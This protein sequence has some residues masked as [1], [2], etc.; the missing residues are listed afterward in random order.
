[1]VRDR[2]R[3]IGGVLP[4][5]LRGRCSRR[6]SAASAVVNGL[7]EILSDDEQFRAAA[8][9]GGGDRRHRK[10]KKRAELHFWTG[11]VAKVRAPRIA[12]LGT[13]CALGKRTTARCSPRRVASATSR[14]RSCT[15][16]R[17]VGCRAARTASCSIRRPTISCRRAGARDR[18]VRSRGASDLILLEGQSALRNPSGPCG[19][20]LMLSG[21]ARGVILQH[22]PARKFF[23]DKS[24]SR[25]RSRP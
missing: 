8:A 4:D 10:P 19:A 16:G 22:A 7:H 12:L 25:T 24:I 15:P 17:P 20:E 6:S 18:L 9:R 14:P 13:D 5:E 23:D 1:V 21:G 11:A 2:Y 3:D